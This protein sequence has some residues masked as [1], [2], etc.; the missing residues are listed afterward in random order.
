M[1]PR[2]S[3][4]TDAG[5]TCVFGPLVNC[6]PQGASGFAAG[7]ATPVGAAPGAAAMRPLLFKPLF[8]VH[9]PW[10]D[11]SKGVVFG[12]LGSAPASFTCCGNTRPTP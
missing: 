6:A 11:D 8:H 1:P 9:V 12:H 10:R 3:G 7:A 5:L 4:S 2:R